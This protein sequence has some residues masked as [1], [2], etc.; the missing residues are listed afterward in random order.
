[1]SPLDGVIVTELSHMVAAPAAG[2]L[3]A[4]LGADVWKIEP[5]SGDPARDFGARGPDG[6]A[7]LFRTVNRGKRSATLDLASND[8]RDRLGRLLAGS[9]V[10]LTNYRLDAL[11]RLG[12]APDVLRT[13]Y[14]RLVV[15]V[16]TGYPEEQPDWAGVDINAVGA[17]GVMWASGWAGLPPVRPA[18][19]MADM[20]AGLLATVTTL[21][22]LR[23]RDRTGNGSVT[24][25]A[26]SDAALY[27]NQTMLSQAATTG[28]DPE[29]IGN[30]SPF[31]FTGTFEAADG[32]VSLAAPSDRLFARL[33]DTLGRPD[34][35]ERFG[36]H[37][38]RDVDR[39]ALEDAITSVLRTRPAEH[40]VREL[41]DA[42]LP[43]APVLRPT[44][45]V[46]AAS[47]GS[48]LSVS[49][50]V[51]TMAAPWTVDGRRPDLG[52]PTPQ[53]GADDADLPS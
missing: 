6:I 4:D 12:L 25:V 13:T 37:A 31:G 17:S 36:T 46:A 33:C 1:M 38:Q 30:A 39:A 18:L 52:R 3:L 14:P 22:G 21:A 35:A 20:T 5:A 7:S 28:V 10:L 44:E 2:T 34:L 47:T 26:L 45:A 29:R 32:H 27:L 51:L 53:L 23:E 16:V 9:D 48:L 11:G 24:R 49:D 8:G 43:C 41:R 42:G 40:W 15:V 50:G 19:S